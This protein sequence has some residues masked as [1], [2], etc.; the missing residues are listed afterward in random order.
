MNSF[1]ICLIYSLS[2]S[3]KVTAEISPPRGSAVLQ[4]VCT[5]VPSRDACKQSLLSRDNPTKELFH[6]VVLWRKLWRKSKVLALT[7]LT[8]APLFYLHSSLQDRM[9]RASGRVNADKSFMLR[10][11]P[12][13][14]AGA[15]SIAMCATVFKRGCAT[16][17]EIICDFG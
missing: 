4:G 17:I 8:L 7:V 3:P 12:T 10:E 1:L 2:F 16:P 13:G 15:Q 14:R 6:R 9:I 5:Q 11:M